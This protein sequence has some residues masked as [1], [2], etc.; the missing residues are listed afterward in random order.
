MLRRLLPIDSWGERNDGETAEE[1]E[2]L[3]ISDLFGSVH[4]DIL[5]GN[6]DENW[7]WG[8]YGDD[9]LDGKEGND[10]LFGGDGADVLIG[11]DDNDTVS[12]YS[13]NEAVEVSLHDGV[14]RG[15]YAEGDTFPGKQTI[16]YTDSAG[17]TREIEVPDIENLYGSYLHDDI[18]VGSHGSNRL[19]GFEG[20]DE[21]DGLGGPDLLEGHDGA[22]V[23]RGGDG[24]DLASY[25]YSDEAVEVRLHSGIARGGGAEGDTF[26]GRQTV[27]YVN[28]AG[29]TMEVDVPDI[30]GLV[31]SAF[32][33]ILDGAHGPN[34]LGGYLG[35]DELDGRE[36]DD[37]LDGGPRRGPA[38]W[39]RRQ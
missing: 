13:S 21:L 27:E 1:I 30:E 4:D 14:A 29:E 25:A 39:W 18:L 10:Q 35:D 9:T 31:G 33:D 6:Q 22:D 3:D 28:S 24:Y 5:V 17:E 37:W 38:A 15:G 16:E 26:P 36:G 19:I 12:Y 34:R 20:D 8:Y 32:D 11:G 2:I 7:L 23:L